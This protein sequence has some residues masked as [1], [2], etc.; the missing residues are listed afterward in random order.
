M[1]FEAGKKTENR[2]AY[3]F[4]TQVN[5]AFRCLGSIQELKNTYSQGY[6][7]CILMEPEDQSNVI[8]FVEEQFQ[9]AVLK[10]SYPG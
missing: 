7:V 3:L 6:T 5:G 8:N 10:E 4:T 9:G 1:R 2:L